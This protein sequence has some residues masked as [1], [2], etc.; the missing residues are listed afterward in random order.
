M[1]MDIDKTWQNNGITQIDNFI[2]IGKRSNLI[3]CSNTVYL[4][5]FDCNRPVF[6]VIIWI[7][8]EVFGFYYYH[9][10]IYLCNR[11]TERSRRSLRNLWLRL[12]Y[13]IMPVR[14]NVSSPFITLHQSRTMANYFLSFYIF[15]NLS[16]NDGEF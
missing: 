13:P 12:F 8:N 1:G 9:E 15:C 7:C 11:S 4:C 10:I 14:A 16:H 2:N 3:K 6:N 5:A